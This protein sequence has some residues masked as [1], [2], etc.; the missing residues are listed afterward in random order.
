MIIGTLFLNH[1]KSR[2]LQHPTR[3][4]TEH[5]NDVGTEVRKMMDYKTEMRG[6][7]GCPPNTSNPS[8]P[9]ISRPVRGCV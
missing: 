8:F 2:N 4:T 7:Q 9:N 5:P 1:R 6:T 3:G